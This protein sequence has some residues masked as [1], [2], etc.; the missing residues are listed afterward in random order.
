MRVALLFSALVLLNAGSLAAQERKTVEPVDLVNL[1]GVDSAQISILLP[2]RLWHGLCVFA[3]RGN[4]HVGKAALAGPLLIL[5]N[6][7]IL[8]P[9]QAS[10]Q[11][12]VPVLAR[13]CTP[14]V[15]AT[16]TVA[17]AKQRYEPTRD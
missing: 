9:R 12:E 17:S 2:S 6:V 8:W 5:W 3:N 13:L 16:E 14:K 11:S 15:V 4:G 10:A 1:E 7:L